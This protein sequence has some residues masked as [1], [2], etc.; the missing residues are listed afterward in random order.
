LQITN[1]TWLVAFNRDGTRVVAVGTNQFARVWDTFSGRPLSPPVGHPSDVVSAAFSPDDRKVV[2]SCSDQSLAKLAA[3]VWDAATGIALVPA[4]QHQDGV[5][6]AAF[7]PDGRSVV[8]ASED[9]TAGI[10][11]A[12]TG[13]LR[14]PFLRHNYQVFY[15]AFSPDGRF[16][17]TASRDMT[18]RVWDASTGEPVTPPLR[19]TDPVE[20]AVFNASGS[21]LATLSRAGRAFLWNLAPESQGVAELVRLGQLMN[22]R[23]IDSTGG[24]LPV[25][26]EALKDL[27]R[28]VRSASA[29]TLDTPVETIAAW[30]EQEAGECEA[31]HHW[32]GA[33]FHLRRLLE[34]NPLN[35]EVSARLAVAQGVL[36]Q[37]QQGRANGRASAKQPQAPKS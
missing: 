25:D 36:E 1:A 11:D 17:A 16:I 2:T 12:E 28:Q 13:R 27:W 29:G 24:A 33:V 20:F 18:A 37:E 7:S 9:G 8:T 4:L 31:S 21:R 19:H 22:S 14:A 32:F 15:A 26:T 10:W 35:P 3:H 30:H 5:L 6:Y 34:L 23:Q